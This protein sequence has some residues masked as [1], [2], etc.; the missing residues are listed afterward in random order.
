MLWRRRGA[1]P[2][3][4]A[5]EIMPTEPR[6][7]AAGLR[8]EPPP[9]PVRAEL[10][11]SVRLA[12]PVVAVQLGLMLMGAVD[13]A[14]LG[15]LSAGALA[16]GAIGHIV[17]FSMLIFGTGSLSALDPLISQAWGAG[18]LRAIGGHLQRGILLAAVLSLP[19]S[20]GMWDLR[21]FLAL[22]GQAPAVAADATLYTRA[23]VWGNLPYLLF[24]VLRQ[25]LLAMG[26]VAPAA[27]AIAFGNVVNAAANY[28]FIFGHGGAPALGLVGSAWATSAGRWSM[29]LW[30]LVGARR[31]LVPVWRGFT[32]EAVELA[33]HLRLLRIGLP[34]GVHQCLELSL[35]LFVALL[36][37]RLGIAALAGHQIAI[38]LASLSFMVP[39]G[40]SG[41]AATRVGHAIGRGDMPGARRTAAV[42]LVLGAGVMTLFAA[43]FALFPRVLAGLYSADPA[44]VG[45]AAVLLPIAAVFQVF[46]GTQVVSAGILR[47]AADTTLPAAMALLG[48]LLLGLPIGWYLG[49]VAGH[50]PRGLWWGLTAGLA[51]VATLFVSRIVWRFRGE[52]ARVAG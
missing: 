31:A 51:I 25:A 20:L 7:A 17:S 8:G 24:I 21:H 22:L 6:A 28:C 15:H 16:A 44:V 35:F 42:C 43:A 38:N 14:M 26:I 45:L 52:L 36:M 40:I 46:D 3:P 23:L 48:Y 10:A 4:H 1:R 33:R 30:L 2:G 27:S 29:F 50:G 5:K 37:G 39:L 32:R 12:L 11:A 19:I 13:T 41:A 18:D 9:H 49:F 47:G 34:I